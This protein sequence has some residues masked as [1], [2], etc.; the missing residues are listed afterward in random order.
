VI[1]II[2]VVALCFDAFGDDEAEIEIEQSRVPAVQTMAAVPAA[3]L[4][5]A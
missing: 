1:A 5:A 3:G 4:P 2:L